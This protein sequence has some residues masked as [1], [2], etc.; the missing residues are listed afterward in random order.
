M[1]DFARM[2]TRLYKPYG[3]FEIEQLTYSDH[4]LQVLKIDRNLLPGICFHMEESFF[5]KEAA[6]AVVPESAM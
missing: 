2:C 1:P 5:T 4:Y 3:F 6:P